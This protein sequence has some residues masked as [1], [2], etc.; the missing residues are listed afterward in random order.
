MEAATVH[1]NIRAVSA[2][3]AAERRERQQRR[4]LLATD[5]ARLRDTGFL[6]TG[7]PIE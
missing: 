5:F 1:E 3:F 2:E 7:V 4:E 6:L